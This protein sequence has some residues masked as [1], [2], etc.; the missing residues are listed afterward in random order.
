[1]YGKFK[2]NIHN[3]QFERVS[4]LGEGKDLNTPKDIANID[5]KKKR[6]VISYNIYSLILKNGE[7]WTVKTEVYKN[8]TETVYHIKRKE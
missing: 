5:K 3:L 8:N 7:E 2:D 6:G 1:M 4:P